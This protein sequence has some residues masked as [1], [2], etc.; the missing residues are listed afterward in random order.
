[1]TIKIIKRLVIILLALVCI[2]FFGYGRLS[3]YRELQKEA[4]ESSI[5]TVEITHP[6]APNPFETI[7]LP[8]TVRA[9]YEAPI[10]AQVSGYVTDWYKDY[11]AEVK[12]GDVLAKINVPTLDAEYEQAK[13]DLESQRAKYNLARITAK[14]YLDLDKS[15]AVSKQ[16]V[17]VAVANR[18][19]EKAKLRAA[20]KNVSKFNARVNF[21]TIV[22]P[23]DGFVTQRNINVGDYVNKEGNL[24]DTKSISN[25]FTVADIEKMRLFVS[26]PGT[27][28]Y[29][30][31]PSL[32]TDVIV[33]QF[34]TRH[35][36]ADFLTIA[37]GFDPNTRTVIAVFVIKNK[38]H[39]LWPGSY[40]TVN[41]TAPAKRD[42]IIIPSS[43]LVFDESGTQVA[44]VTKDNKIHF[45]PIKVTKILDDIIEL[46]EGIS[47]DDRIVNNPSAALLE[48]DQVRVVQPRTGYGL[49]IKSLKENVKETHEED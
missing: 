18:D 48:G 45:K 22:A 12:K 15:N 47:Q 3:K 5:P 8:G 37:K 13:A 43:S 40:A 20:E 21:K 24:S 2:L 29:L 32:T 38:D 34:A 16:S 31:K 9:W 10:Y 1:M 23:F 33:P 36:T 26:V 35:F 25:L 11:G 7:T 44:T 6:S 19:A 41:I 28:A 14:R 4:L 49:E 39:A 17:S 30:L 27:F 42:I 46:T